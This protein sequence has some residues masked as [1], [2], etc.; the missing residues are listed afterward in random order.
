MLGDKPEINTSLP[1]MIRVGK[2]KVLR[3]CQGVRA[4]TVDEGEPAE[5]QTIQPVRNRCDTFDFAKQILNIRVSVALGLGSVSPP[6]STPVVAPH[7]FSTSL[8]QCHGLVVLTPPTKANPPSIRKSPET[9][10]RNRTGN[11]SEAERSGV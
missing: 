1:E 3:P 9:H 10:D 6:P 5:K 4:V 11:D 7:I 8:T 2:D